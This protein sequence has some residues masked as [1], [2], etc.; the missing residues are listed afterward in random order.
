MEREKVEEPKT[1]ARPV[2]RE[3]PFVSMT[4]E[5]SPRLAMR[6]PRAVGSK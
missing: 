4:L 5:Q 3:V 1:L 2:R 6:S